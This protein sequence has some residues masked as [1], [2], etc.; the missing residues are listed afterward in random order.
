MLRSTFVLICLGLICPSLA[1]AQPNF[2]FF[3]PVN[4]P[5]SIQ[6]MVHRGMAMMAPENSRA[7]IGKCA[8]DYCEW[9]EIDVR[10]TKDGQH[11]VIHNGTVNTTTNGKG[12]VSELTLEEIKKL[13]A[14]AWFAARFAG[15][16]ILTLREALEIAKGKINLYLDCKQIDPKRLVEDV[17][18]T[19]ME[20]QVIIYDTPAILAEVKAFSKGT[21]PVMAKYRQTVDFDKFVREVAPAAVEIDA[22]EVTSE[23]CQKFHAAGIK[24]Q[25][26]VLGPLRDRPEVWGKVIDAG[27]DW[28]QTDDPAG[29]LFFHVRRLVKQFPVMIALHRGASRYAPENSLPAI[30]EAA[31]LGADFAEI[32]IRTSKDGKTVLIHDNTVNRTTNGKGSVKELT[33]DELTALSCGA[34][35][36][37]QLNDLRVPSFDEGLANYGSQMGAYLDAKDVAPDVLS[38]MIK[39]Y[40]LTLRHVVYQSLEYCDRLKK[41][42]P[43]VRTMPPLKRFEDIARVAAIGAYAVDASWS[44]LSAETIAECHRNGIK[45]FSDALGANENVEQYTKAIGWGIDCIQTDHPLRVLRAI[46]LLSSKSRN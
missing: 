12:P 13:D 2:R 8:E 21:V 28:L 33:F 26:Q 3:E 41:L 32:D 29:L 5:R 9:A 31:R 20:N 16:E 34:W 38:A 42:D 37:N 27:V 22:E 35:F 40:D 18:A 30:R 1:N 45:V 36:R 46:E 7:A 39:K 6:V 19:G 23:V 4:P 43:T 10:L 25:A 15:T 11:V 17:V 44:A 24:V 14:G